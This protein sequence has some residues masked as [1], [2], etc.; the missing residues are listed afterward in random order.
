MKDTQP[1]S[2]EWANIMLAIKK[3]DSINS[4]MYDSFFN[5]LKIVSDDNDLVVFLL[6]SNVLPLFRAKKFDNVV[7]NAIY[8]VTGLTPKTQYIDDINN[9]ALVKDYSLA[10]RL[11]EAHINPKNSFE[12]FV[13]GKNNEFALASSLAVAESPGEIYNPL[14]IYAGSGLGKTHLMHAIGRKIL[15]NN[16]TVK[17]LYVTSENFTI[18]LI[19][20]IRNGSTTSLPKFRDKYRNIDVL[21]IDDIQFI[22]GKEST[23]EEFFHTFETLVA[24]KKQLV[25]ASDKPPRDLAILDERLRSRFEQGLSPDISSPDY[26]TRVAIL[27]KKVELDGSFTVDDEILKYIAANIQSNIRTLEGCLN[28]IKAK[29]QLVNCEITM[30]LA[31]DILRDFATPSDQ[32]VIT[33]VFIAETVAEHFHLT[34][35]DLCSSKRD[36]R[37]AH[38]RAIAMFICRKMT[39]DSLS[40][41]ASVFNRKDHSTALSAIKKIDDAMSS[42]PVTRSEVETLL[43]KIS[44]TA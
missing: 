5:K 8:E 21:L 22:I 4:M 10:K 29:S 33:S 19:E 1:I 14:F 34:M 11:E 2:R 20:A 18:E 37:L 6:P 7:S 27:K 36:P 26:E 30:Q 13:E 28:R 44:P 41:I 25:I 23:Q 16:P 42:D 40:T 31:E 43:K 3:I 24:A 35:S 32:T 39:E 9:L 17:V 12:N 15:E 38:P